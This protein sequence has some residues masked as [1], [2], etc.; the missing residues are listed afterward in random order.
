M[1]SYLRIGGAVVAALLL[2]GAFVSVRGAYK[3]K[4]ELADTRQEL[5]EARSQNAALNR[6]IAT[7]QRLQVNYEKELSTLR[8]GAVRPAP[9]VRLCRAAPETAPARAAPAPGDSG[10]AAPSGPL[11]TA[12]AGGD[13]AGPDIGPALIAI[14]RDA[15]ALLARCRLAQAY[16]LEVAGLDT[17]THNP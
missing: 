9:V 4:A 3:A 1:L 13:P 11:R 16:S 7:S 5:K 12:D 2:A 17:P 6:A 15:D 10:T 8:T 14:A